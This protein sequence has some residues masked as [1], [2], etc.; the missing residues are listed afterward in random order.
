[1]ADTAIVSSIQWRTSS[2]LVFDHSSSRVPAA[3][4]ERKPIF[5]FIC[6]QTSYIDNLVDYKVTPINKYNCKMFF[7]GGGG[8]GVVGGNNDCDDDEDGNG[9]GRNGN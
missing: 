7:L 5:F 4:R 3:K 1:M 9:V 8:D 6:N 2:S